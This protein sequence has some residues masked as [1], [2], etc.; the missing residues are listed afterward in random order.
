MGGLVFHTEGGKALEQV[1]QGDCGCPIGI[2]G[3]AG[4][5]SRQPSL[6]VG[7]PAHNRRIVNQMIN[8]VLSTQAIL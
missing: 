2:L 7:N 4:C 5:G 3:Q 6:L 8:V 1:A